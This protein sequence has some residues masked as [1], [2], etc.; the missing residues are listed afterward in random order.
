MFNNQLLYLPYTTR[1]KPSEMIISRYIIL[2]LLAVMISS[3]SGKL[4]KPDSKGL[5]PEK[6]LVPILTE[7]RIAD[8]LLPNPKIKEW[9]L[10][11]DSVSTYSYIIQKYGYS[12][13]DFD[14]TMHYYFIRKPKELIRIHD[15]VLGILSEMESRLDKEVMIAREHSTNVWP[16]ERNYYSPDVAE[17]KSLDFMVSIPGGRAY[18]LK[19]TATIFPDDQSANPKLSVFSCNSD[20]TATGV[21]TYYKIP[22]YLK[23]GKP[24]NYN[25]LIPIMS[26]KAITLRGN[27]YDTDNRPEE[28]QKHFAFEN[29]TLSIPSGE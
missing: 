5:I 18:N 17:I 3:C 22:A 21:R 12:K 10:S 16:G 1:I 25:L 28:C 26:N 20:S 2:F 13:E 27:L 7:L 23:D 19:F 9:I 24:H 6:D 11:V 4:E 8:G 14:K 15:K 29:I